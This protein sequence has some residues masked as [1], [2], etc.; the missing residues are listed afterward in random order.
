[1]VVMFPSLIKN[2]IGEKIFFNRNFIFVIRIEISVCLKINVNLDIM[3][4]YVN[5]VIWYKTILKYKIYNV[6]N[7][8]KKLILLLF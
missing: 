5:N 3:G 2:I 4:L 6:L 8:K 7:A 1:M